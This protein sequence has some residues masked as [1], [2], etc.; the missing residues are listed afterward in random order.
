[1][2]RILWKKVNLTW[3]NGAATAVSFV[4]RCKTIFA[5]QSKSSSVKVFIKEYLEFIGAWTT[6]NYWSEPKT[7][8]T[9]TQCKFLSF[10]G[11]F[12]RSFG[13]HNSIPHPSKDLTARTVKNGREWDKAI[14]RDNGK[15]IKEWLQETELLGTVGLN[16][17]VGGTALW[18][19]M[20]FHV[21][22]EVPLE[23]TAAVAYIK[24]T[25]NQETT[26]CFLMGKTRVAPLR[27]TLIPRLE[28]QAALYAAGLKRTIEDEMDFK[29]Y[30]IC[31]WSDSMT[32]LS[33]MKN[34]KLKRKMYIENC[35][36]EIMAVNCT[37]QW[38]YVKT[39]DNPADQGTRGLTDTRDDRKI[40]LVTGTT[41][42]FI[43]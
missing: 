25:R 15:A 40:F 2:S 21:I 32:V 38:N 13:N 3:Q 14:S 41:V 11:K 27:Q 7:E 39:K 29:F 20:E 12:L 26:T 4:S 37:N 9:W 16:R 36:S 42:S 18:D 35:I 30:K 5:N 6:S 19:T 31:L 24:T 23:A 28:L 17:L 34:F 22:C 33:L 8:K 43:F 10:C 1:M